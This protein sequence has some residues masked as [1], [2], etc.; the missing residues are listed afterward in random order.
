MFRDEPLAELSDVHTCHCLL[1]QPQ[2]FISQASDEI[3]GLFS[4]QASTTEEFT[5]AINYFG[6][7]P[8]KV[9][10]CDFFNIFAEFITKFEVR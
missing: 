8:K 7:D 3:Q 10:T 6:D 9:N 5:A 2:H 4:L 1:D